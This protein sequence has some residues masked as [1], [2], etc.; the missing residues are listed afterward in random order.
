VHRITVGN[1][2]A[3]LQQ[4][5]STAP[6]YLSCPLLVHDFPTDYREPT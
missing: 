3:P 2:P 1:Q 6:Q 5:Q 4:L